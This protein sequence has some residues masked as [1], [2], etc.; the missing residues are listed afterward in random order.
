MWTGFLSL[1]GL[2]VG[3]CEI[4]NDLPSPING[5]GFRNQLSEYQILKDDSAPWCSFF[6]YEIMF[7]F[8]HVN[9]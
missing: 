9:V 8:M 4:I 1:K 7:Q 6:C 2:L 5:V 3:S